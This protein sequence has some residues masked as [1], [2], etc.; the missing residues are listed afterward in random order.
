[1]CSGILPHALINLLIFF[2]PSINKQPM[3]VVSRYRRP[4]DYAGMA[5]RSY[6]AYKVGAVI[7]NQAKPWVE[8][9]TKPAKQQQV[10]VQPVQK[11]N[12]KPLKGKRQ[13]KK[14]KRTHCKGVRGKAGKEIHQIKKAI[15]ELKYSEN[16]SLGKLTYRKHDVYRAL[17]TQNSQQV[18]IANGSTLT[19]ME[20]ALAN[21]KFFNP[22]NPGTLI[23]ANG[24]T[25]TYQRKY[26]F[27]SMT[28][29]MVLRNNYQTDCSFKVYLCTP[30]D[31]TNQS[32]SD[33]WTAG[34]ADNGNIAAI[35]TLNQYP[36]DTD[37]FKDLWHTKV[38]GSYDLS[39]GQ[40]VSIS[41]SVGNVEYDPATADTHSLEYQ[42]DFKNFVWMVVLTG[43]LSHD[44]S[45]DEQG[46]SPAGL[47]I[48]RKNTYVVSYDAGVNIS[49]IYLDQSLDTPTNGFVQSHQPVPDNVSYSAA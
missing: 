26:L 10:A 33:A 31:D 12:A 46:I 17:S 35:S 29:K 9:Y 14:P 6:Q 7:A 11:G 21:L 23:T 44:S 1:M 47:D 15:K 22:S 40:S 8:Y 39:P 38:K 16:A 43:T 42:K 41:H 3:S 25:G 34:I 30:K 49:F 5:R 48:E 4:Y 45:L 2:Y 13:R 19:L 18:F 28:S 24:A 32:P 27:K 37:I 20:S 36:S